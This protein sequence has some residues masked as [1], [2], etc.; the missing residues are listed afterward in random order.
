MTLNGKIIDVDDIYDDRSENGWR[1]VQT[2]R[3]RVL[4]YI[5]SQIVYPDLD[6]PRPEKFESL[7]G[8]ADETD[9]VSLRWHESKV[10]GFYT[11][12]RTG[13]AMTLDAFYDVLN[14]LKIK[15]SLAF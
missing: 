13:D 6:T 9:V 8:L 1:E 12:K 7:Y 2:E 3:D 4:F 15:V 10:I 14:G 11:V 5:L